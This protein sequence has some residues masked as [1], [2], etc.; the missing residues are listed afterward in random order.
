MRSA[1]SIAPVAT[2]SSRATWCWPVASRRRCESDWELALPTRRRRGRDRRAVRRCDLLAIGLVEGHSLRRGRLED[3][4]VRLDEA[5][6]GLTAGE[7][8]PIVSGLVYCGVIEGCHE[9]YE[10]RRAAE[11]T[12][13][14]TR[15]CDEQPDLVPF[16][17]TCLLH[18]A[19]LMQL[20]GG[21][22]D[23][24]EEARRAG[25]RFAERADGAA[26]A[27]ASYREGELLRLQ[28]EVAR[29][30]SAL[31]RGEPPRLRA[32]AGPR[33]AAPGAGRTRTPP[34]PR[35]GRR[36]ARATDPLRRAAL[37]PAYVEVMLAA[38]DAEAGAR[39]VRRARGASRPDSESRMLDALAAHARGAVA[40]ARG[41]CRRR[42]LTALRQAARTWRE[43]DV[44]YECARV[45][46]LVGL[47]CRALGDED[48][49][50]LE[51]EAARA[52][53]AELGAAPDLARLD[54]L[55]A[56][57]SGTA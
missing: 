28:G 33:A 35:S 19:E 55:P 48:T 17:G 5:M 12:E 40:L 38:G 1:S 54:D 45:R 11:W 36:P 13:A 43:L 24:L 53:F 39:G 47:A 22:P 57:P 10:L 56:R 37:L 6:V 16:T 30:R 3:G 7:L 34:R 25:A 32:A 9:V 15:W 14:L 46:V 49:A 8:S 52:V 23:A 50:A 27:Q 31:P 4:L 44:P 21:W 26:A 18:R 29:L 2:A 41:R 51:L 42:R 20:Q